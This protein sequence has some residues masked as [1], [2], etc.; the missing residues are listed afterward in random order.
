MIDKENISSINNTINNNK[1]NKKIKKFVSVGLSKT[2]KDKIN[3]ILR[4]EPNSV[5]KNINIKTENKND[6]LINKNDNNIN[7]NT[8]GKILINC[9]QRVK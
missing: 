2:D 3:K 5:S 7:E 6:S 4:N 8:K 9:F 1:K